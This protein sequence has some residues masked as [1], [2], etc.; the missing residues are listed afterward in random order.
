MITIKSP[1]RLHLTLID[2]NAQLGRVDGGAGISMASP[3]VVVSAEKSDT[4]E[5]VGDSFLAERMISAVK[6]V[7]PEDEGISL[8]IEEDML[9]HVGFG[10]GTQAALSAAAAVNELYSLDMSVRE[11]AIAVGRGGT[12]GIGVASF[13]MGGFIV[14]GGHRFSNKGSFY[15]S[16]ASRADPAP[17]LFRHDFPDWDIVLALPDT[18]GAHD[19]KEVNIFQKECPIPLHEVQE[20]SH[21]IL[22]KMM[23]AIIEQDIETFGYCINHIQSIGFKKREVSLQH[24]V[25]RDVMALMQDSGAYGAGMSSFGPAVYGVVENHED[26]SYIQEDVQEL[27]DRTIGGK[28]LVTKANNTGAEIRRV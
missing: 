4:I 12:S 22:M 25:V 27:L 1:S 16:S 18:T 3:H 7:L 11:L 28:V 19:A 8:N 10:S 15:P 9:A 26:A 21:I 13:E 6:Q 23:P 5:V 20:L 2:M 24:Q 17:V 14:D